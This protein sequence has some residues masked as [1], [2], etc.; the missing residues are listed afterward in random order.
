MTE[1]LHLKVIVGPTAAGKT[2]YAIQIAQQTNGAV[3][4]ADSRQLYAGMNS[5]TAKPQE[6]WNS[7]AHDIFT[8][9]LVNDIPHYLLNVRTPNN[10]MTLTEWQ[11]AAFH[12]IDQ[13]HNPL[14]VGGT[15]LY[16]DS[17]VFNY[18]VPN[19]SPNESLRAELETQSTND[20]YAK[21]LTQDPAAKEFI[22]PHHKRRIIRALEVIT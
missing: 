14:L 4:S 9:D 2:D 18:S 16:V 1:K 7:N 17:I 19:V 22:E 20:L 8:A 6:A 11:E 10:P 15:M 12:I 5:G 13:S 3:I 21:L